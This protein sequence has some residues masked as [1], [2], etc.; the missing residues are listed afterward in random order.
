[1]RR[2]AIEISNFLEPTR[3]H[4]SLPPR[5]SGVILIPPKEYNSAEPTDEVEENSIAPALGTCAGF[6]R[7]SR[8]PSKI[9]VPRD[10]LLCYAAP[11]RAPGVWK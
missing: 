4:L 5:N 9:G 6:G 8:L 10:R 2:R 11:V 7:H 3:A 1:M